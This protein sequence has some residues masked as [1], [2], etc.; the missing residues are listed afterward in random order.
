MTPDISERVT[1]AL[2]PPIS[3]SAREVKHANR[4]ARA[5]SGLADNAPPLHL[6]WRWRQIAG[7]AAEIE[8]ALLADYAP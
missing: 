1:A 7:A 4:T 8:V 6:A 2:A 3:L 5:I